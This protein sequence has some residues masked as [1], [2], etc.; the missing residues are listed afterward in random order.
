MF[1]IF[2]TKKLL[3]FSKLFVLFFSKNKNKEEI[4]T[5]GRD[6]N[7]KML[8]FNKKGGILLLNLSHQVLFCLCHML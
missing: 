6:Q 7:D 5:F 1:Q 2:H 4:L 3:L 8:I